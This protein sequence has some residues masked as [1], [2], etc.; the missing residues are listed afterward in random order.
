MKHI[1]TETYPDCPKCGKELHPTCTFK[2]DGKSKSPFGTKYSKWTC[3]CGYESEEF[4]GS[5]GPERK[6]EVIKEV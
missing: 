4:R 2:Q 5:I 6:E 1:I 3:D